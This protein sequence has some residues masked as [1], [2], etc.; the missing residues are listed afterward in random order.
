MGDV[1]NRFFFCFIIDN[2]AY[3]YFRIMNEELCCCSKDI[4]MRIVSRL[5]SKVAIEKMISII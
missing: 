3:S 1:L 5:K 2:F 4:L